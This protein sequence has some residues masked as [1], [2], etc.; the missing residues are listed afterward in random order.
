MA[1]SD[2]L[3]PALAG[4]VTALVGFA[5]SFAVVIQGLA[6][7]GANGPQA[8]SGLMA[9]AIAMGLAGVA[10]SV[11]LR[12]PV[13]AAWS[14]PGAALLA[15]TGAVAGGWPAAVGAFLIA[16]GLLI[17]AGLI[18]PFGRAVAA[19]PGAIAN[20]MLAGVLFNLCLAPVKAF[21]ETPYAA[22]IVVIVW[23]VVVRYRRVYATPAAALAAALVIAHDAPSLALDPAN[24]VPMPVLTWPHVTAE[25]VASVS[26]PLFLVTMA[27]QNLPGVAVLKA[28][29]YKPAP[30][31]LIGITGLFGALAAPFGGHAVNLSAITAAMC[32]SPDASPDPS[33]RWIAATMAGIVYVILGVVSGAAIRIASGSPIL[34]EA[35]AGLALLSALGSSLHNA[36]ADTQEREAAL[37]TF[38]VAASGVS[39]YGVGGAFWGLLTGAVVLFVTRAGVSPR[40]PARPE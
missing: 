19:I 6:A 10:L 3:Q 11:S 21:V 24:I 18:K 35:V 4:C 33:R 7:V 27:S 36:L 14:T 26:L 29:G 5:G 22:A 23:L 13:S 25:A 12:Q 32:A 8:A 17:A 16:N 9:A 30:S 39:F 1:R 40:P 15:S 37:A 31:L 34:I 20:A 2:T 38:I 28:Y